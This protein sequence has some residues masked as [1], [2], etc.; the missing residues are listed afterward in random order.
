MA[1]ADQP[2][3]GG[4]YQG[5]GYD[6]PGAGY[7]G[8]RAHRVPVAFERDAAGGVRLGEREARRDVPNDPTLKS[9]LYISAALFV[10]VPLPGAKSAVTAPKVIKNSPPRL[11]KLHR[12]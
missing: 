3:P 9:K 12:R 4:A 5:G 8:P 7:G 6:R 2:F 1:E 10:L 11:R